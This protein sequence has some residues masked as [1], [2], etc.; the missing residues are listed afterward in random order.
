[1]AGALNGV[2]GSTEGGGGIVMS[3]AELSTVDVLGDGGGGAGRD[4]SLLTLMVGFD[5]HD[6][7]GRAGV[8][9]VGVTRVTF[10]TGR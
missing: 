9:V 4:R 10:P 5:L 7:G 1:M 3:A 2:E 6:L 8:Q